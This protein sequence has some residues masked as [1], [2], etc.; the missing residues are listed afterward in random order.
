[1][2]SIKIVN[3]N[4]LGFNKVYT[5]SFFNIFKSNTLKNKTKH[6]KSEEISQSEKIID[7]SLDK[8][9]I[10]EDN[11]KAGQ[12]LEKTTT[13]NIP[14]KESKINKYYRDDIKKY[15]GRLN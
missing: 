10:S 9:K 8:S 1:M 6:N 11:S 4:I 2:N 13:K 3:V 14:I 12:I 15:D 7:K 5:K